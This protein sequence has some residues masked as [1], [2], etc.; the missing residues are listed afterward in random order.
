MYEVL[1]DQN[2]FK[3]GAIR[4]FNRVLSLVYSFVF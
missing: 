2:T 4:S 1:S 3:P